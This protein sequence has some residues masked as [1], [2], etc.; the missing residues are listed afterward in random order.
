M[1]RDPRLD[2][3]AALLEMAPK[4]WFKRPPDNRMTYPCFVYRTSK[5]HVLR[6]DNRVY[7]YKSCY[8]VIYYST[9][10]AEEMIRQMLEKFEYCDFDRD[11]QS[12]G[13]YHY[14]FTI[15]W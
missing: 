9:E 1:A 14:S 2:L 15:Y 11:Y 3:Q 13:I 10:P 7:A 5:P 8:N 6:A 12:D 4:A